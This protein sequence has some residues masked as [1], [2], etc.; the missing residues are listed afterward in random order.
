MPTISGN[1]RHLPQ[2]VQPAHAMAARKVADIAVKVLDAH[3]VI[4]ADIG[5]L[6]HRPEALHAVRVRLLVDILPD[7]VID[8]QSDGPAPALG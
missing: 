1:V 3:L 7:A 2:R 4:D 8:S 6:E 5:A